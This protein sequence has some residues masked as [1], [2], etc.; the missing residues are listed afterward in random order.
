[1]PSPFPG[2]NPYLEQADVWTDFHQSFIV[3]MR[4][5]LRAQLDPRYIV[6][7]EE[8]I[9]VHEPPAP[10]RFLGRP[11]LA[12]APGKTKRSKAAATA[13]LEPPARVELGDVDIERLSR[14]EIRDRARREL[15]TALELLRRASKYA[16]PDRE[17][18]EA[19]RRQILTS[20]AHL[21]EIDLLRGGR[22][23]PMIDAPDCDYCVLV[24]RAEER[25]KAGFWPWELREPLP[26]VPVP[27]RAPDRDARLNLQELLHHCYDDAGYHTY[28]YESPPTPA[29]SRKDAT[30]AKQIVAGARDRN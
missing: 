1:M 15:I 25:P 19:K 17:Q 4:N 6:K 20:P 28:L 10:K 8:Q 12:V 14:L 5:A 2:M 27:V 26:T 18:Y 13:A 24:S 7:I 16:G 11:D 23:M 29:L 3:A 21:V 9:Y 22:R 30:W